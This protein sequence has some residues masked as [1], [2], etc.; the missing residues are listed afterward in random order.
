MLVLL[1][2]ICEDALAECA[3]EVWLHFLRKLHNT[4]DCRVERVISTDAN[5]FSWVNL[6][7]PLS[8]ND[9]SSFRGLAV[10]HFHAK[11]LS[12]GISAQTSRSTRL[13]MC[14]TRG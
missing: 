9:L 12:V 10:S 14:H 8:D 6:G 3:V 2:D 13:F 5:I 11:A 1:F 7:S 4:L